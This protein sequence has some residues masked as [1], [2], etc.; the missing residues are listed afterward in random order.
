MLIKKII[1]VLPMR[2]RAKLYSAKY[3]IGKQCSFG[4]ITFWDSE[5]GSVKI[6]D[7]VTIFRKTEIHGT[8]TRPVL[9]GDSTFINQ[10][11]V[12]RS[13]VKIGKNVAIGPRVML[14]S[15]SHEVGDSNKRAGESVFLPISVGDGCWIGSGS[16]IL[17][18]VT[19]G[20]G[21]V[22]AAGSLVNKDCE[23]NSVYAG[24]PAKKI[25]DL[26]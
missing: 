24:V 2:L 17:G 5:K 12:V 8:P 23:P 3:E 20:N 9:I 1:K 6:G 19:I 4:K 21:T 10:Q 26:D 22:I 25:K 18:G 7:K 15:D 11:C 14:I 13:N 16:T